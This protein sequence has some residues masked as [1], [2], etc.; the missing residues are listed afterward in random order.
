MIMG[1]KGWDDHTIPGKWP[2]GLPPITLTSTLIP[3]LAMFLKLVQMTLGYFQRC[4]PIKNDYGRHAG[5]GYKTQASSSTNPLLTVADMDAST[6]HS[7]VRVGDE[8]VPSKSRS[9]VAVEPM[10]DLEEESNA[11]PPVLY[12][13]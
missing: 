3:M 13:T 6:S 8:Y 2:G 9:H 4:M 7:I 10:P 12:E 1:V 5:I 11:V